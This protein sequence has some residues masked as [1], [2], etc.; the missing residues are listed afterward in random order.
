MRKIAPLT[1]ATSG[2]ILLSTGC[3]QEGDPGLNEDAVAGLAA[4]ANCENCSYVF[5]PDTLTGSVPSILYDIDGIEMRVSRALVTG[6]FTEWSKGPAEHWN[7]PEGED[8]DKGI[9]V[10]WEDSRAETRTLKMELAVESVIDVAPGTKVAGTEIVEIVTRG[11]HDDAEEIA[12]GLIDLG[13]SVVFL[14]GIDFFYISLDGGL[15]GDLHGDGT[16]TMPVIQHLQG[17][18]A[19][20]RFTH[21]EIDATTIAELEEAAENPQTI[22]R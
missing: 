4:S 14:S 17:T 5:S 18:T 15:V 6:R 12:L 22:E 11:D 10:A 3:G 19:N 2:I 8:G 1:L 21:L 9:E 13:E 7:Y 20:E 16:F